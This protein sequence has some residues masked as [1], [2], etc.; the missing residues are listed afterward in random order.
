MRTKTRRAFTQHAIRNPTVGI[1]SRIRGD[2]M[3]RLLASQ[4]LNVNDRLVSPDGN[5]EH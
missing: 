1:V 3:H 4:Q 5:K 2:L